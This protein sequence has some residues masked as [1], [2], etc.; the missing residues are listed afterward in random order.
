M[1]DNSRKVVA[2][3]GAA[4]VIAVSG[5]ALANSQ[6]PSS[7]SSTSTQAQGHSAHDAPRGGH[8]HTEVTGSTK[9]QVVSAVKAKD[10]AVTVE[11]VFKRGDGSYEVLGT[12][13]GAKVHVDVSK[14]LKTISART[15][16]PRDGGRGPG[17]FGRHGD[18][19]GPHT[20]T[21]VTGAELAKVK[22]AVNSKD[23]AVSVERVAEDA[24]GSY[25]VMGTKAK[26]RV[27]VEVSKDL[28][29]VSVKAGMPGHGP[30]GGHGGPG[31]PWQQGQQGHNP[32]SPSGTSGVGG[33]SSSAAAPASV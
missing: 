31:V 4:G 6:S 26:A 9:T 12:K 8:A 28:K 10:A 19:H 17:G 18:M 21:P 33:A 24:D 25:D 16:G 5:A 1:M 32:A 23:S 27:M 11:K 30:R 2:G 22:A 13:A 14:D 29:T 7:S 3:L 20:H 15:G